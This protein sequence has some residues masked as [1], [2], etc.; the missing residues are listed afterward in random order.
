MK[1]PMTSCRTVPACGL[2]VFYREAGRERRNS[3]WTNSFYDDVVGQP[4]TCKG[5]LSEAL[6]CE[7]HSTAPAV[8]RSE[9]L[10]LEPIG[11]PSLPVAKVGQR[12]VGR[13]TAVRGCHGMR[14]LG[15]HACLGGDRELSFVLGD[16]RS[17]AR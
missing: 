6:L 10:S 1:L 2:E 14:R 13:A 4:G 17:D 11:D 16:Q 8:Q 9:L 12:Q 3:C 7:R 5:R 15:G